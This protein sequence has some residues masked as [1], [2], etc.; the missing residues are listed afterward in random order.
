MKKNKIIV[1]IMS[2]FLMFVV[3]TFVA[4]KTPKIVFAES[5]TLDDVVLSEVEFENSEKVKIEKSDDGYKIMGEIESMS[6]AQVNAFGLDDVTHVVILKFE[7]DK[8][9]T[10][11]S[12][13]IKGNTTK[14]Y[15]TNKD[16]ENYVGSLSSLL[17]NED[18]EDA[19]CRLILSAN[20]KEYILMSKYTDGTISELKIKIEATLVT[21]MAE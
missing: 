20:T 1:S 19:Y 14:V 4:C 5:V 10:I 7:F 16:E 15:S 21:A 6:V 9:R 18:G 12:F 13:S 17:D 3:L 11:D 8:E 2:L